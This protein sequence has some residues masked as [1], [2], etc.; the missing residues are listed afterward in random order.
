M[1]LITKTVTAL[2]FSALFSKAGAIEPFVVEDIQVEGLQRVELGTFFTE[3]PIRVGETL[4]DARAPGIIRAIHQTGNFEFVKLE[5][6]GNTLKIVVVERPVITDI[7]LKGNKVLKSEQLLEGMENAGI[8]KGEVL[9]S[10]VLEK[11]EQ[12]IAKQYYSNGHYHINVEKK[13]AEL[14][15]NRVQL[16]ITINEGG[17]AKIKEFNIV[18]NDLFT[19]EKLLSQFELTTGGIFTFFTDDNK[20]NSDTLEKDLET[21]TSYY[22]DRGYL[23]FKI[24]STEISLANNEE[25]IYITIVIEEGEIYTVSEI[26]ILGDFT[27]DVDM[28][29]S[30][31]P[32]KAGDTY[33]A[34]AMAF[35]EE[36]IKSLLGVY[37][38]AFAEVRTIP[39][40][41]KD[42]P[43]AKLIVLVEPG[44]RHYVDR[45]TFE[46]N[47]STNENVLR[48][49]VRVQEGGSLS[50]T[51]VERSKIRLQRLPYIENVQVETVKKEGTTDR[52]DV[53]FK[54][55]ERSAAQI[56]GGLGYNDFYGMTV[57]GE[58]SHSNFLGSGNS[59]GLGLNVN[60]AIKSVRLSY[61]DNYFTQDGVALS[62]NLNYSETDYGKLNLIAQSMDTLGLGST[63]YIPTGE[64]S[65]F[66]LGFNA[67]KNTITSPVTN[68]QR[69]IDF[70]DLLGY[71]ARLDSVVDFDIFSLNFGYTI[72]S[73]NRAIF[74]SRGNRHRY[75]LEVGTAVGDLEFYKATYDY[76]FY[77]PFSDNDWIFSI[78]GGL[79]YGDGYGDTEGL[80]YF[81]NFYGGGSSSLRGFETNTIGPRDIQRVRS[82]QTV[83][84]PIPG[85]GNTTIILP[86]EYDRLY[87]GRYSVGGNAR[88]LNSFELIFP[89]PFIEDTS[90]VRTSFFVDV[91]NV[92]DTKF[93]AAKFEG[94]D[95]EPNSILPFVPDYSDYKNY[96]ASYGISLQW[97]SAMGPLQF[98]L[99]RPLKSEPY[100]DSETFT[101]SIGQTF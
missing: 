53:M 27:L 77:F 23:E 26:D 100:D 80:P 61:T 94:L 47:T 5:K 67:S 62:T 17:S 59:V 84:S 15:R 87:I 55:K 70:F 44:E 6:K 92:W 20:Y 31:I 8:S 93:D 18:G 24:N 52:A 95:I 40:V 91:G 85:G 28:L 30:M 48:R 11:I 54:I 10:F 19:D 46:G 99:S 75:G 86:S 42:T 74:P 76:N 97:Y 35:A 96:R 1:R 82:T 101:F 14:S 68:S 22:K 13:L 64:Y 16:H 73:L 63:V 45:I 79:G 83:P 78:R 71:D 81:Q 51:L 9:D 65:T 36:Q 38:Y 69:V 33:S 32:L 12:E 43:E 21:L 4:D 39:E 98:S 89:T 25:D 72:N 58:L 60:K 29:R 34:A 49:E 66:S 41:S 90:N 37:G 7:I 57:N 2:V 88:F 56:S 50:S 3:L